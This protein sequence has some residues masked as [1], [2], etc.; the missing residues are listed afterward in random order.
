MQNKGNKY[1]LAFLSA[2]EINQHCTLRCKTYF[3][4]EVIPIEIL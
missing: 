3:K 4:Y 2:K 1:E